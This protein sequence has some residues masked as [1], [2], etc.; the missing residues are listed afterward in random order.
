MLNASTVRVVIH[1][2]NANA[3][4]IPALQVWGLTL[5]NLGGEELWTQDSIRQ[6][7]ETVRSRFKHRYKLWQYAGYTSI[8][9]DAAQ[10]M[11]DR[12]VRLYRKELRTVS[13]SVHILPG[14]LRAQENAL[15]LRVLTPV[16][17]QHSDYVADKALPLMLVKSVAHRFVNLQHYVDLELEESGDER[18]ASTGDGNGGGGGTTPTAP[19]NRNPTMEIP[20]TSK[21]LAQ[22]RIG[23]TVSDAAVPF[24]IVETFD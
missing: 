12:V 4:P 17:I 19:P 6:E 2:D 13:C 9:S 23:Q 21:L 16:R 20:S 7:Q 3:V 8:Y 1:N 5:K 22:V 18:I 24:T 14:S 15:R 11:A 10:V